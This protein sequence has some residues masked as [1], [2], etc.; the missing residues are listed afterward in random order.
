MY[1]SI[2]IARMLRDFFLSTSPVGL[3]CNSLALQC[4]LP[5][6]VTD[7]CFAD[8]TDVVWQQVEHNFNLLFV[9]SNAIAPPYASKY[10]PDCTEGTDKQR[11]LSGDLF[12][13]LGLEPTLV[14]TSGS[15]HIGME[16]DGWLI[17]EA[18]LRTS[19]NAYK[20][21]N[22]RAAHRWL[23][24]AHMAVWVP[25]FVRHSLGQKDVCFPVRHA[26]HALD[27]WLQQQIV[28]PRIA[29]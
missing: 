19:T 15:D 12:Y 9:G 11:L 20:I 26:L 6:L 8:E 7:V 29:C 23:V 13:A 2:C 17:M 4:A 21:A 16:L 25:A 1:T 5:L 28:A 14:C 27:F 3:A 24:C 22:L 10:L 18:M